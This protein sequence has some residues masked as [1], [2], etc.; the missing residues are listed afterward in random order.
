MMCVAA[1][2]IGMTACG[3]EKAAETPAQSESSQTQETETQAAAT[4]SEEET[5]EG[6]VLTTDLLLM[7]QMN[8]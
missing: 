8:L 2:A 1:M 6:A 3:G 4:E 7:M 5:A